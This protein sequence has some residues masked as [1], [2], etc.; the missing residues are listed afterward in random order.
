LLIEVIQFDGEVGLGTFAG[1]AAELNCQLRLWQAAQSSLP[2]AD[3]DSPVILLGGYMGVNEREQLPYLQ[4]ATDR[5]AAMVE[6]GRPLLAICLGG[7]LLAYA[8]GAEVSSQTRQEKGIS[9]INLTTAG[10]ADPL[11]AGLPNPFVSFEWHNDSFSLPAQSD[12]LAETAACQGQAFRYRNAWGL[13]FHPEVDDK[14]V[15]DWCQ[16]T[17]SGA[18]LLLDFQKQKSIY[19][20][21]SRQLLENFVSESQRLRA[22]RK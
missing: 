14:I 19:Y 17:N 8:L 7:Q 13:Q 2:P 22:A 1:W 5:T 6:R 15:A 20:R 12:L 21:H 11:F 4:Q 3:G 10:S 18:S 16:R 9:R